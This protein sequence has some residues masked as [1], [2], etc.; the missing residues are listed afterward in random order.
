MEE[1]NSTLP[2]SITG[3]ERVSRT[4]K[5]KLIYLAPAMGSILVELENNIAAGSITVKQTDDKVEEGWMEDDLERD[6]V[7]DLY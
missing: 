2:P 1:P 3:L 4:D 6:I 5:G 7:I